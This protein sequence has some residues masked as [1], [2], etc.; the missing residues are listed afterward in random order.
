M[1]FV[2]STHSLQPAVNGDGWPMNMT[3]TNGHAA[4]QLPQ[5][6]CEVLRDLLW[7][8]P[9]IDELVG[10]ALGRMERACA[11]NSVYFLKVVLELQW[12]YL[13]IRPP[14]P[15]DVMLDRR[16]VHK[17]AEL[18]SAR[19]SR[20]ERE[21]GSLSRE[22]QLRTLVAA[23][24]LLT[25]LNTGNL[26]NDTYALYIKDLSEKDAEYEY[27]FHNGTTRQVGCGGDNEYLLRYASDLV[28][29][30]APDE[31]ETMNTLEFRH[32]MLA[33]GLINQLDPTHDIAQAINEVQERVTAPPSPYF[34]ALN[35][36][37][38]FINVTINGL[39]KPLDEDNAQIVQRQGEEC[40]KALIAELEKHISQFG[41]SH[42]T[43]YILPNRSGQ[44]AQSVELALRDAQLY[45]CA[46]L[47]LLAELV[48][49]FPA[50]DAIGGA[51]KRYAYRLLLETD[52]RR[53]KFKS[54]EIILAT[55]IGRGDAIFLRTVE[56]LD[57]FIDQLFDGSIHDGGSAA[58]RIR[59]QFQLDR[60]E[61]L[62]RFQKRTTLRTGALES[63][64][65]RILSVP[66]N[67]LEHQQSI[68]EMNP[69][70]PPPPAP[71]PL[72]VV[73][74]PPHASNHTTH[75]P[76]HP[77]AYPPP[78]APA[79]TP[80]PPPSMREHTS[81]GHT[82]GTSPSSS[83]QNLNGTERYR[84]VNGSRQ[85]S[86]KA[87]HE[88]LRKDYEALKA[89]FNEPGQPLFQEP[90][91]N[92]DDLNAGE[93]DESTLRPGQA[94][95]FHWEEERPY[96]YQPGDDN[97][98]TRN[99][100]TRTPIASIVH[101]T[102]DTSDFNNYE[103]LALQKELDLNSHSL[104]NGHVSRP[105]TDTD[106]DIDPRLSAKP[107][108]DRE[109]RAENT[110][111]LGYLPKLDIANG[112]PLIDSF[113]EK[114]VVLPDDDPRTRSET[115]LSRS[116]EPVQSNGGSRR[117]SEQRHSLDLPIQGRDGGD[118]LDLPIQTP[119]EAHP[120]VPIFPPAPQTGLRMQPSWGSITRSASVLEKQV[121][122]IDE[123]DEY[124]EDDHPPK[125]KPSHT[126]DY[127]LEA[128]GRTKP[129]SS[130][131]D[132]KH[133]QVPSRD[134]KK[135]DRLLGRVLPNGGIPPVITNLQSSK[136]RTPSE[137]S[138]HTR[139][140][141]TLEFN[142]PHP[143]G[144]LDNDSTPNSPSKFPGSVSL[145]KAYNADVV[146]E[147]P[148]EPPS[149]RKRQS[150][151]GGWL[152]R[153]LSRRTASNNSNH[154]DYHDKPLP[155]PGRDLGSPA[156]MATLSSK[157]GTTRKGSILAAD[158]PE[159]VS[160]STGLEDNLQ[161]MKEEIFKIKHNQQSSASSFDPHPGRPVRDPLGQAA[162][163]VNDPFAPK[164][165]YDKIASTQTYRLSPKDSVF[166]NFISSDCRHVV[167]MSPQVFQVF[168]VPVPKESGAKRAEATYRLGA[169]EGLKKNK[170]PWNY[171][172]GAASTRYIATITA[173]RVQV[174]DMHQACKVIFTEVTDGWDHT[175]VSIAADK[176]VIGMATS[177]SAAGESLGMVRVY[178]MTSTDIGT[179]MW[180]KWKD[181]RLPIGPDK[182]QD[183]PHNITV[184]RDGQ[185]LTCCT[186]VYG[187]FFA[188][189][190]SGER[191]P[192][193]ISNGRL[194]VTQGAGAEALTSALLFPDTKHILCCTLS[195]S[196]VDPAWGGCFTEPTRVQGNPPHAPIRQVGL[197]VHHT[198]ISQDGG[199]CAFLT[200]T[201]AIYIVPVVHIEGDDNVTTLPIVQPAE[202]LQSASG[203]EH[204]GKLMFSPD[205][206]RLVGID[207]R[208]RV[209]VITFKRGF[210]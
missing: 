168:A 159:P 200:R 95:G 147:L 189:D 64:R 13:Y 178:K 126:W 153:G 144:T 119:D 139:A 29:C 58:I 207:R 104:T 24:T 47:D 27:Q 59:E 76:S 1:A 45:I 137:Y 61:T 141:E 120:G 191:E 48:A 143:F 4:Q 146:A 113:D 140:P 17:I 138:P 102:N 179:P 2:A 145:S 184:T 183:S 43:L 56:E 156:S 78:P 155:Q 193:L 93:D 62:Q 20:R 11:Y 69:L 36:L 165:E 68:D 51:G 142:N 83:P 209:I 173:T 101:G 122:S 70:P 53:F 90:E 99:Q 77:P 41:R 97:L 107:S 14:P 86:Q 133:Q 22:L 132:R 112:Q 118:G 108:F 154:S 130:G 60:E 163:V 136:V 202:K 49:N 192:F 103:Y 125:P 174:H 37:H 106:A 82:P 123:E 117:A 149:P 167:F 10:N 26:D 129:G 176:L 127:V 40:V 39:R 54:L 175:C 19:M 73:H 171:K 15:H 114:F 164:P 33:A 186:P 208:G 177:L 89:I 124:S 71:A 5:P 66:P 3:T 204:A 116:R 180:T 115:N 194:S 195:T 196:Q 55:T 21:T 128:Q 158:A 74:L 7:Y 57:M 188:W 206:D 134:I 63:L 100:Q 30:K 72:N 88:S 98:Q 79:R 92:D 181:I 197:K 28:R 84:Q 161:Q 35:R 190:M 85:P 210:A 80:S 75:P 87:T 187:Y 12:A 169:A 8:L 42:H 109:Q 135:E 23:L 170:A 50:H 31:F 148:N 16:H 9:G 205:G 172:G 81:H 152:E 38:K 46:L 94:N 182:P 201:G 34:P 160:F 199:A 25:Y 111:S 121:V 203:P 166:T 150:I 65:R 110:R 151:M 162:E 198:T 96:S 32:Y 52:E 105:S 157:S 44:V 6:E 91:H 18:M 67:Q 131:S 185:Y